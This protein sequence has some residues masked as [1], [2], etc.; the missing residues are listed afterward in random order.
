MENKQERLILVAAQKKIHPESEALESLDELEELV[1]TAGGQVLFKV[2][3]RVDRINA[4]LYI[5]S[6]KVE[7]LKERIQQEGATGVVFDDELS[8]I[9]MRNLALALEAKV[10]DRT[11]II[12]DIFASRAL[13]KEGIIQVEMAQ[14]KYQ[15]S[16]LTGFGEMLSRQGGGIGSKGPGEKKL[17]LDKR[18]IKVRMEILK[19]ELLE[20]EKH[21]QLIRSRREKN[22]TPVI[23][24]VGYTNAGKSTLLNALCGSD[25]YVKNQLFATLD[26]TTRSA[27]LPS[28]GE[29]LVTD[30]VGFIR[31]LPHHLVKAFYSTLEEAKY[32]DIIL[33]VMDMSS[34]HLK[35]HQTVV[36]ETLSKLGVQ[37]IPIV[38]VYNKVDKAPDIYPKTEWAE[39][40]LEIS[41]KQG[42]NID[43]LLACI[44]EILYSSRKT[45]KIHVPYNAQE[46]VAFCHKYGERLQESYESEYV[47][48]E[49]YLP[50]NK[51]YKIEPYLV[52]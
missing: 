23:A 8:P 35:T 30:T 43:S 4:G 3:Q 44:E 46:V 37:N 20:I 49:G 38:A 47:Y 27:K 5:G 17:E 26:P 18:H 19:N 48:L 13:S 10:M 50:H 51:F 29:I 14:L 25:V 24:I 2:L 42:F 45:F 15:Y 28:G 11:M 1:E 41:A 12:L 6:G 32:A 9:Q 40:H 36:Q 22:S 33:H 7:E 31:K 52:P 16:R 34:P 39:H 21:R